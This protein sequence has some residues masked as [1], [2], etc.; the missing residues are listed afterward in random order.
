MGREITRIG[1][2]C[3]ASLALGAPLGAL[4]S[5]E[6]EEAAGSRISGIV[7]FD[8]SNAYYF[9]GILN[10]RDGVVAQPWAELYLNLYSS[11]T[12]PIRDVTIGGGAWS[13]FHSEKTLAAHSPE[14]LYET[15]LYPMLSIG[16]P[17]GVSFT[18]IYYFYTSPNGAFP[19]V[20]ELNFKLA[21][22]DSETLGRFALSPWVNLAIETDRSSRGS[23]KGQG[24]QLGIAPTLFALE[25]ERFP[26]ELTF[27]IEL[28]LSIDDY[29]EFDNESNDD[30]FGY[31][32]WGV[33]AR[34]PL[35]F[36]PASYGSWSLIAT[37]KGYH[38]SDS[39]EEANEGDHLQ[40]Q[41]V[42]SLALEF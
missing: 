22:D 39:L 35:T 25:N 30:G 24:I 7:Q 31:V 41:G 4:A 2:F 33:T 20:Q 32:S 26:L 9:R 8:L 12:G 1:M 19:T 27:P 11:E 14:S 18:T 37:G 17:G 5:D 6:A 34:L 10:E 13:S 42:G 28:G 36:V 38:F 3:A 16:L 40:A 15:D 29:Y 23:R 21:W